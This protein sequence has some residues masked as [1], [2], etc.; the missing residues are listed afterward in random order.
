MQIYIS[1]DNP[2]KKIP[3]GDVDD[4]GAYRMATGDRDGVPVGW[5]KAYVF[6]DIKRNKGAPLPFHPKYL[7]SAETPFS[8]E[9]VA[10]PAPGA[11]DLKLTVK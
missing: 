3:A 4:N 11:Y 1:K 2:L 6:F 8:V 9:V 10:K 5:Y 7:E